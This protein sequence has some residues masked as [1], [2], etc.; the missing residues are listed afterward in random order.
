[1]PGLA[2]QASMLGG[3]A[4]LPRRDVAVRIA[5]ANHARVTRDH[6]AIAAALDDIAADRRAAYARA[7]I[8]SAG[9]STP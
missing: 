2:Q 5:E 4:E 9:S 3:R 1:M 8:R 6:A 7:G